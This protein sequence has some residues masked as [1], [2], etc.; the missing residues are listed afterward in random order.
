[1]ACD[2][3][4]VLVVVLV[5]VVVVEMTRLERAAARYS[6]RCRRVRTW[7]GRRAGVAQE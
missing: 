1:M 3:V 5:V 4:V 6:H 7:K 2:A